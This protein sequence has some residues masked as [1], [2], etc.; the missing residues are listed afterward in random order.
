MPTNLKKDTIPK[1]V[2]LGSRVHREG[3]LFDAC[4]MDVRSLFEVCSIGA[5]CHG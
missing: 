2:G 3:C 4:P 1:P 5:H